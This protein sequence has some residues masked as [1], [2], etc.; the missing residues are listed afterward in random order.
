MEITVALAISIVGCV[1]SVS[2]FVLNRKDKA[3]KDNTDE[4]SQQVLIKYRLDE[5][6]KTVDKILDKLD[7]YENDIDVKVEKAI[8]EHVSKYHKG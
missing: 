8:K 1:I 3:V 6:Q 7:T 2:S 5:L 4:A